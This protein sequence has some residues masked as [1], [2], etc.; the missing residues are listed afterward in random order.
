[1][2]ISLADINNIELYNVALALGYNSKLIFFKKLRKNKIINHNNLIAMVL[3]KNKKVIAKIKRTKI[4]SFLTI[5][6]LAK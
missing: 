3:M 5:S 6:S 4:S 2:S 1:M